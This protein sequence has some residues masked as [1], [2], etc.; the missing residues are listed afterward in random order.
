MNTPIPKLT[1]LDAVRFTAEAWNLVKPSTI[2][3]CWSKTGII[4][5]YHSSYSYSIDSL[6]DI[7]SDGDDDDD[8]DEDIIQRLIERFDLNLF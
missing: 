4:S 1:I 5:P 2:A 7:P 6:L 8:N 3:S